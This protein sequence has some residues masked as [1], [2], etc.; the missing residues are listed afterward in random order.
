MSDNDTFDAA[1]RLLTNIRSARVFARETDFE[2]LLE[3]QAKLNAVIE[4]CRE[5]AERE[6]AEREEREKK[7]QELLQLIADRPAGSR[8]FS[9]GVGNEVNKPLLEQIARE[10]GGVVGPRLY[11]D[12]LSGPDGPAPTYEKMMRH[13]VTALVAGML[14]N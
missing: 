2:Q 11:T 12:A 3:M 6:A 14:K 8:V 1:R 10:S 7:R 13:N 5:D 9:I 4:E